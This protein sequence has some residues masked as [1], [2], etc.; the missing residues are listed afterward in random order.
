MGV[1]QAAIAASRS[2]D[3]GATWG[4][5]VRIADVRNA[6]SVRGFR[7]FPLPSADVDANGRVWA[8]WHDCV[9]GASTN[10]VFVATSAD[11]STW[12]APVAVTRDRNAVLPAIGI[13]PG[14]G[15]VAIAYM[16]AGASGIDVELV[17]SQGAASGGAPRRLSAAS[18]PVD[19]ANDLRPHARRLH[20]GPLRPWPT[21]RRVGARADAANGAFRQAVYAT[22]G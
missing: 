6:C 8:T 2:T 14:S 13:D 22:R 9:P 19:A 3:G 16:V 10:T 20:L 5:P 4:A 15:R 7:A 17:E 11:G 1:G 12:T 18:I 21:T